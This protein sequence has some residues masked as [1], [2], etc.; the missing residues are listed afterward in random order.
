M[1]F[2]LNSPEDDPKEFGWGVDRC[3]GVRLRQ[4]QTSLTLCAGPTL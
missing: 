2:D 1:E 4:P 3:Q